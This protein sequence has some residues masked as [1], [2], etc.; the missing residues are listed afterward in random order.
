MVL[1]P[2][3]FSLLGLAS[4]RYGPSAV[5][6]SASPYSHSINSQNKTSLFGELDGL[7]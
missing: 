7:L 3:A 6:H 5:T 2:G 4:S 1:A